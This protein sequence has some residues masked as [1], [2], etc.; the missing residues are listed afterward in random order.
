MIFSTFTIFNMNNQNVMII[1]H[2]IMKIMKMKFVWNE[3][4]H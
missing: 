4:S 2:V 1:S 3:V